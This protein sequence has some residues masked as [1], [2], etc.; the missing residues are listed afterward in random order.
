[1]HP[2]L[3]KGSHCALQDQD[4]GRHELFFVNKLNFVINQE[5]PTRSM[6]Y[7]ELFILV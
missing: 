7:Q 4:E 5:H 6:K 2:E 1:M 3:Q